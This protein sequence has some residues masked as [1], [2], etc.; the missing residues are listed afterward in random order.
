MKLQE[1][2]RSH[3]TRIFVGSNPLSPPFGSPAYQELPWLLRS[4]DALFF[5]QVCARFSALSSSFGYLKCELVF[6]FSPPE[7]TFGLEAEVKE[8]IRQK[9]EVCSPR[10]GGKKTTEQTPNTRARAR[11]RSVSAAVKRVQPMG[12]KKGRFLHRL[13]PIFGGGA[14][15]CTNA[16]L[17]RGGYILPPRGHFCNFRDLHPYRYGYCVL[18]FPYSLIMFCNLHYK[19]RKNCVYWLIVFIF[20]NNVTA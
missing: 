13:P 3:I 5:L 2:Q 11:T 19:V 7:E 17:T 15:H 20:N 16:N 6:A 18:V 9:R 4:K 14:T 10:R 12:M 8:N 1:E